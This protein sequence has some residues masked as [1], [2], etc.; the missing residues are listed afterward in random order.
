MTSND[1]ERLLAREKPN[2][3]GA[4]PAGNS[5]AAMN[6]V[7]F[8]ELTG[9]DRYRRKAESTFR[10]FSK[11]I[12]R[13]PAALSE[14]LLALDFHLDR[15]KQILIVAPD[16]RAQAEPFLTEL[17]RSFV[18]NRI[19]SVVAQ[20]ELPSHV[21][22]VPL[23]KDKRAIRGKTT[24]YVCEQQVCELPTSDPAVFAAQ[25]L[26]VEPLPPTATTEP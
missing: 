1:H 15:A 20:H 21:D 16:S 25:I 17:R 2:Y 8:H 7:R 9:D 11:T 3:D 13:S 19:L 5:V 10:A 6:L 26:K 14:M 12:E 24:A 22:N 23:L 4:E 18:P